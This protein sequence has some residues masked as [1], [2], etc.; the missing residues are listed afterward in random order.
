MIGPGTLIFQTGEPD[1]VSAAL[2]EAAGDA[3]GNHG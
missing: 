2:G 1:P 3:F